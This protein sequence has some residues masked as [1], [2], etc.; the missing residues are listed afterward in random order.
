M[1]ALNPNILSG[2]NIGAG[3]LSSIASGT[4]QGIAK[5]IGSGAGAGI[6]AAIGSAVP[7]LGTALG[8]KLGSAI[9]GMGGQ[10]I[11]GLIRDPQAEAQKR[12]EANAKNKMQQI[13]Q[14]KK[15]NAMQ[16]DI[17]NGNTIFETF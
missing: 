8:A 13:V 15:D 12:L 2:L 4:P 6:G 9:G 11:G 10:L 3:A 17:I 16:Y 7:I 5:G 1:D 14:A